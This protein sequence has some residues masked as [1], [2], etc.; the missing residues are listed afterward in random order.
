MLPQGPVRP[1]NNNPK[2]KW[3]LKLNTCKLSAMQEN[4]HK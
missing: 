3:T 2:R 1:K 4:A